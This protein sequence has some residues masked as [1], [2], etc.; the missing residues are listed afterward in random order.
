MQRAVISAWVV[1]V[2][3]LSAAV[4]RAEPAPGKVPA[5]N[6]LDRLTPEQQK[7]LLAGEEVYEPR[8]ED[9][10]G[11]AGF[12][13]AAMIIINAPV[14]QCFDMFCDFEKQYLYFPQ[15]SKSSVRSRSQDRVVIQKE[16]DYRVVKIR[17]THILTIDPQNHRVGFV[18]DPKGVNDVK[19]SKGF[20]QF[21]PI[22]DNRTLFTYGMVKLDPGIRVPQFIRKYMISRDLPKMAV[23]LKKWIESDG[24]WKK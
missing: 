2:F 6:A 1:L 7:K 19:F 18:T 4:L 17:Y 13:A 15:I 8:L 16:L 20:F 14:E 9:A 12:T 21:Q 3:L 22:D 24:K 5:E 11:E 10:A 23:N